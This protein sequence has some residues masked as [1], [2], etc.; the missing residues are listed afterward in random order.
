MKCVEDLQKS[1][2][3]GKTSTSFTTEYPVVVKPETDSK[4]EFINENSPP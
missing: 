1:R 3:F 4:S 2:L